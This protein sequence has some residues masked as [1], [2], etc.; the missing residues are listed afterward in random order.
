M[1]LTLMR[2][3]AALLL[4]TLAAGSAF[5]QTGAGA[6]LYRWVD[7][8]G[9]VHYTQQAPAPGAA[10]SVQ[11]R[12]SLAAPAP[13]A[14][15]QP[16]FA[17][18]LAMKNYPVTLFTSPGCAKGCPEARELLKKRGV[19]FREVIVEYEDTN[20]LLKKMTGDSKVPSIL[21]GSAVQVGY[22]AEDISSLLDTAGYPK[23]P[24]FTGAPPQLPPLPELE[25]PNAPG[26][27]G[28]PQAEGAPAPAPTSPQQP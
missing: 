28:A 10:K 15:V 1:R 18:Q 3:L 5:S 17:L 12:R 23:E 8:D 4:G 7:K 16:P 6:T 13:P 26:A 27:P 20:A 2:T 19:P 24:A 22:Q 11:E 14:S 21:V 9:R 25:P